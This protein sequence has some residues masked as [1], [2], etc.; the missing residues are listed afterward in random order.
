MWLHVVRHGHEDTAAPVADSLTTA[1]TETNPE[2]PHQPDEGSRTRRI[3]ST[4]TQASAL[5]SIAPDLRPTPYQTALAAVAQPDVHIERVWPMCSPS[6]TPMEE[7][8]SAYFHV[9]RTGT[10]PTGAT[11]VGGLQ[12]NQAFRHEPVMATEVVDL[13]APVPP[14]LIVDATLG[15]A[16]HAAAIL[17]ANPHV[18]VLGIDRDPAAVAAASAELAG[19]GGRAVVRRSRFD[20]LA[21]IVRRV[22]DE[23]G[24]PPQEQGLVGALF[25]L[26]VSSPQLDVADRGFS[27]RRDAP[28]DMRMD[29]TSGRTAADVVNQFDEDALVA[30]FIENGEGRFAR[31]IARAI[32]AARPFTTTGQLADV[33]RTAI[34]AA[35]RR[36]GGHPARR[37]FQAIRI[38][39]NEELDQLTRGLGDALGLLRPG[40]RCVVISYHSGEDRLVKATFVEAATGGCHCPPG[41]PCV[42][43][44]NPGYRLVVRGSRRPSAEEIDRNRRSEAARL[45][46]VER[47]G[48]AAAH[49]LTNGEVA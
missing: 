20:D 11:P 21:A 42:C 34:P 44:A 5:A 35:T 37:V 6:T 47:I 19:F 28:L 24:T 12:M 39:V 16:G 7:S 18:T 1:T 48:L 40:G 36:T 45:R 8:S 15:G 22:Q 30:L 17:S 46:V 13:L 4:T 2:Q 9:G 25:D 27:Y 33:V 38:A 10:P 49:T 32:I 23:L 14:G 41:L 26:G 31:R 29:P 3:T 43:G